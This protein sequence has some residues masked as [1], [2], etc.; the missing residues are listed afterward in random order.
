MCCSRD[1]LV[2]SLNT[3]IIHY[4]INSGLTYKPPGFYMIK[5][6][7]VCLLFLAV[8]DQSLLAFK[9]LIYIASYIPCDI[10]NFTNHLFAF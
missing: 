7:L 9:F 1:L 5:Y 10:V 2:M 8:I 4:L 6:Q 3:I